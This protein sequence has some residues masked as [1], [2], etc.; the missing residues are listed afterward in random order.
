ML[1]EWLF[2]LWLI[3]WCLLF[4]TAIVAGLFI[5]PCLVANERRQLRIYEENQVHW[6]EVE[7]IEKLILLEQIL[8][9]REA[10][11]SAQTV[12]P[13]KAMEVPD[14]PVPPA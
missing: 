9:E 8:Q 4:L 5:W 10:L 2:Q 6:I 7:K 11:G 1:F 3:L 12:A 14:V 13:E